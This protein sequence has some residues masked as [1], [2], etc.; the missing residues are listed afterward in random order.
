[1]KISN[2]GIKLI[3]DFEGCSL[4]A[5]KCPAGVWTIG[6]GHTGKVDGKAIGSGM[7]I[8][9]AKATALLK[10]D[11]ENYEKVVE[12]CKELTF[13]PNQNQFDA[14][15]SFA[16]NCGSGNLKTLVKG[17]TAE[18]VSQKLLL[19]TKANGIELAGLIRRRKAEKALFDTPVKQKKKS[20]KKVAQE[21][22]DGAWGNGEERKQK[23]KA[24]GYDAD[25]IQAKV[26]EIIKG[27]ET[28]YYKKY[29]G[30][31]DSIVTA[32]KSIGA[33][34]TYSNRKKIAIANGIKDYAGSAEQNIKL[35]NL[36]KKGKLI[37]K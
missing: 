32:L 31:S 9:S 3:K 15:V 12:A 10:Q 21:V 35:L 1:M 6:Y 25:T 33:D 5:Y 8:T 29:T 19:Y 24:A 13:S 23:L 7:K 14:L 11:L 26:N 20:V 4:T 30:K 2:D 36:L 22:I 16:Y 17:R 18:T 27:K 34:S 28:S 37:K